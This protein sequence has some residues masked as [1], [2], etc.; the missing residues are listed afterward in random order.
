[1]K[2]QN[3]LIGLAGVIIIQACQNQQF[4][5]MKQSL[6]KNWK[7]KQ[8]DS[9]TWMNA[10]VPG[11]VH[12]D[13]LRHKQIPD[14]FVRKNED[15]VQWVEDKDWVYRTN[16]NVDQHLLN[17]EKIEIVFKGLDT[18]ADVYLNDS[19]LLEAN[20]MFVPYMLDVTSFL[21]KGENHLEV[22]F[23]SP[24]KR[25]M[26][27]AKALGYK[28]QIGNEKAP[29]SL[30]TRV[31][32][33]K[34]PFHY[35]W[36]WGPRLVTSGIWREVYLQAWDKAIIRD[37]FIKPDEINKQKAD[38]AAQLTVASNVNADATFNVVINNKKT[39]FIVEKEIKTGMNTISIP[40]SID[41]PDLWWPNGLGDQP[42]YDIKIS[43]N[44][45]GINDHYTDRIGV[46][47]LKLVQ[48]PDDIGRS[49]Y[50]E[51]NGTPVFMKGANYIPPDVLTPSVDKENYQHVISDAVEANMN[52]LR[53]WGGAI[54]EDNIFY[55]LCDE[56]GILVWQD[57]MFACDNLPP[58]EN[59]YSNVEKEAVANVKRLRNHPCMALW[60]GNNENLIAWYRWGWKDSYTAENSKAVWQGYKKIFYNILPDAV[61]EHH[62]GIEYWASSPSAYGDTLSDRKSGD[63]HDWSIWFGQEPFSTYWYNIPRFV[64][65]YGLQAFPPM[66]TI[67]SFAIT[68][69]KA[70]RSDIMEHRQ[71]SNME[72]IAPG[73]NGNEMI[74]HY[75]LLYYNEPKDFSSFVYL[76]NLTQ[77]KGLKTAIEAHRSHMPHCMG[78]LYWQIDDCWPTMSWAT[79]DYYGRWKASH[80]AVKKAFNKVL[81]VPRMENDTIKIFGISDLLQ[82]MKVKLKATLMDFNGSIIKKIEQDIELAANTSNVYYSIPA[83]NLIGGID[84]S[85]VLLHVSLFEP[86]KLLATNNLYFRNE[87]DL[88]I[89]DAKP[90]LTIEKENDHFIIHLSA[91]KLCKDVYLHTKQ[92]SGHFS[93]NYF[94]LIPGSEKSVIFYPNNELDDLKNELTIITLGNINLD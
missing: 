5:T 61:K 21:V 90:D 12:S 80:Y 85:N 29:D 16:F 10:R 38:Y 82:P 50:F 31:F 41:D 75:M 4:S 51:I 79:V 68:K 58:T 14:P 62:P 25:G 18:Y 17:K 83:V 55:D 45:E 26:E 89:P 15:K 7:F 78:S 42:L 64:S 28:L 65:E 77:A 35:G 24:V 86:N 76:S 44:G 71:R 81:V 19:L 88:E 59:Y 49:F 27:K 8:A 40:F 63:E 11:T 91:N 46:R 20:N 67:D 33:R 70:Y 93:D 74:K 3:M 30:Q 2:I 57:F 37:V 43:L 60:C 34:A 36:D 73:M 69:D 48:K 87:K 94:D 6:N 66:K 47:D 9:D 1:M 84:L 53:V 32:T 92:A 23:H 39:P 22:Y 56:N 72:W 52:M 54:Y 13:L